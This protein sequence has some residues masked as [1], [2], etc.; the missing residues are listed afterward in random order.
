MTYALREPRAELDYKIW[1]FDCKI[2]LTRLFAYRV[3]LRP[4]MFM[5]IIAWGPQVTKN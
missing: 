4:A 3:Q 5:N 2:A 1:L